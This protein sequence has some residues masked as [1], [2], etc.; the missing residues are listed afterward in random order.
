MEK[1]VLFEDYLKSLNIE[2]IKSE[3]DK[4]LENDRTNNR[5]VKYFNEEEASCI[6]SALMELRYNTREKD[7]LLSDLLAESDTAWWYYE[8]MNSRKN[9]DQ[10]NS[11]D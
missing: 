9:S 10:S 4:D 8:I 11:E 2:P 6:F 5:F 3:I 7:E 1:P